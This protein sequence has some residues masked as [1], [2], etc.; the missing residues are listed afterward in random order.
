VRLLLDENVSPLLAARLEEYGHD[1]VHVNH[2]GLTGKPDAVI[3]LWAAEQ[4]RTVL[5]HDHDFVDNLWSL[6]AGA[7]SVIKLCQA[8]ERA[9]IGVDAHERR[10]GAILPELQRRLRAGAVA[11]VD[12]DGVRT[13][14]LPLGHRLERSRGR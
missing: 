13:E 3:M 12:R 8:G 7:P 1:A 9:L 4:R 10:L 6:R 14:R 11:V 2:V 5:T